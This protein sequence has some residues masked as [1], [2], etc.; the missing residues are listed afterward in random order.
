MK[1]RVSVDRQSGPIIGSRIDFDHQ[2]S[3][4]DVDELRLPTIG[5]KDPPTVYIEY[6]RVIRRRE[7]FVNQLAATLARSI[8]KGLEVS[9]DGRPQ[10][11]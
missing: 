7:A 10:P 5:P 2:V 1:I 3:E 9:L 4:P 8:A 11:Y 6:E